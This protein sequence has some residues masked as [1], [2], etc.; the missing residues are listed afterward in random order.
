M[1]AEISE[2]V[3]AIA[4]ARNCEE[5]EIFERAL[6]RGVEDLWRDL[7]LAQYFDDEISREEAIDRLDRATVE[8]ADRERAVVEDDVAWG[9]DA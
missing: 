4:D 6:E 3:R 7:T 9:L 1:A 5:S 8:R 2:R